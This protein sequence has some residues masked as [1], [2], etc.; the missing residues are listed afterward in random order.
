MGI[1]PTA[2][3]RRSFIWRELASL[4]AEFAEVNGSAAAMTLASGEAAE[5]LQAR[6]MALADLTALPRGGYKG[7]TALEWLRGQGVAIGENNT[8]V[9]QPDGTRVARL[10]DSEA[11][12]LGD[13][14]GTSATL[15]RV[16]A[17]WSIDTAVGAYPVPRP[18][19]NFWFAISGRHAA[20]MMAKICGVDL[21]PHKFPEGA[22]AQTSVARSSA[23]VIRHDLGATLGYDMLADSAAASFMWT[24]LLDA[25]GEFGG[26]PVGLRALVALAAERPFAG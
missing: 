16:Q 23:I 26:R 4:G 5:T 12:I 17:A 7:W 2:L 14:V 3:P 1:V 6:D 11:L 8:T 24:S 18:D 9:A 19:T 10:A 22:V 21:R 20:E 13:L 15:D 25:M